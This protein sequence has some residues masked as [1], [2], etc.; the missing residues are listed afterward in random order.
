MTFVDL[1]GMARDLNTIIKPNEVL[2]THDIGAVA[3]FAEY[4]VLDLVGLVNLQV[5]QYHAEQNVESY[6][7]G[8]KPDYLLIFPDWDRFFLHINVE[9]KPGRYELIKVYAGGI[10]RPQPYMLYRV[11]Y[12]EDP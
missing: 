6:L 2:A 8:A 7:Q 10:V 4:E 3:Y 5:G 12:A 11:N 9:S 1:E